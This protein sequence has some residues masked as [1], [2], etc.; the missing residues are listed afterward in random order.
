MKGTIALF[1]ALLLISTGHSTAD[2]LLKV[3]P[4]K[5][6]AMNKGQLCYQ[7]LR[8][9]FTAPTGDYCLVNQ[10]RKKPLVCWQATGSGQFT[11]AFQSSSDIEYQLIDSNR[12]IIASTAVSVA[13]VYQKSRKKNRWRLF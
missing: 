4:E 1:I 3:K 8:F 6:V 9:K 7:K 12:Q 2:T 10:A 11:H 13:W 5:C